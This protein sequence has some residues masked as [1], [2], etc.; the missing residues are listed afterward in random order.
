M[1]PTFQGLIT[2]VPV[3]SIEEARQYYTS[4][5]GFEIIDGSAR[6]TVLSLSPTITI[7]LELSVPKDYT[8]SKVNIRLNGKDGIDDYCSQLK[9]NG[10]LVMEPVSKLNWGMKHFKVHDLD[11]NTIIYSQEAIIYQG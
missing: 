6:H 9:S 8:K 4:V 10:A 5:L 3:S 11:A 7:Q 1:A 2:L